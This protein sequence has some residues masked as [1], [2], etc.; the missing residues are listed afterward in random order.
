MR[1]C[2]DQLFLVWWM[3]WMWIF[4]LRYTVVF[5]FVIWN[6]CEFWFIERLGR[7]NQRSGQSKSDPSDVAWNGLQKS[8]KFANF[9][10]IL[11]LFSL[12]TCAAENLLMLRGSL[13]GILPICINL[14][15]IN[16]CFLVKMD[17]ENCKKEPDSPWIT[18][19]IWMQYG[20]NLVNTVSIYIYTRTNIIYINPQT[21]TQYVE[22]ISIYPTILY[23]SSLDSFFS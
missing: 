13:L 9:F 20:P 14:A 8:Q 4:D 7:K 22:S 11:A 18:L 1:F 3:W 10:E 16:E 12:S 5:F 19:I 2:Q 21:Y 6:W 17:A 23:L 15:G